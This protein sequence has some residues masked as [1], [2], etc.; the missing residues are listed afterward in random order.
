MDDETFKEFITLLINY[1]K[2]DGRFNGDNPDEIREALYRL[3]DNDKSIPI[4][5]VNKNKLDPLT[6]GSCDFTVYWFECI[7][8]DLAIILALIWFIIYNSLNAI[9][10][11]IA[12]FIC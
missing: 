5:D 3:R 7:L 12:F 9:H 8:T 11:I 1:I 10:H 2:R 6:H 4:F